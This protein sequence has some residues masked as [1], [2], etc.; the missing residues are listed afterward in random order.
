MIAY[1]YTFR[2]IKPYSRGVFRGRDY[3]VYTIQNG[4]ITENREVNARLRV[5]KMYGRHT[6]A[7]RMTVEFREKMRRR[8]RRT[9][10]PIWRKVAYERDKKR[11]KDA[12]T[13]RAL[14]VLKSLITEINVMDDIDCHT[15]S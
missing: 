8:N 3:T 5:N 14:N 11:M 4:V 13:T 6:R 1:A 12:E 2:R 10:D 7:T 9:Y 15:T